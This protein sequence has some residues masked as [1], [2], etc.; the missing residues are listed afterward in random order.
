MCVPSLAKA[1]GNKTKSNKIAFMFWFDEE[2]KRKN[3]ENRFEER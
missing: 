2:Y 1:K 3:K